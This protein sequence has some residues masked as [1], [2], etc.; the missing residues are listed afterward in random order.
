M[1]R[2]EGDLNECTSMD[3]IILKRSLHILPNFNYILCIEYFF[4]LCQCAI[5]V[6]RCAYRYREATPV[7][8]H[9]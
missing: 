9:L 5:E 8:G 6:Y 1:A 2:R 3:I 7:T 4:V